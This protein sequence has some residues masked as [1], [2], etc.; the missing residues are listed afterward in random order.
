MWR[1]C[2]LIDRGRV[3]FVGVQMHIYGQNAT[4]IAN[5]GYRPRRREAPTA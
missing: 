4:D 5:G 2:E 3:D 1:S